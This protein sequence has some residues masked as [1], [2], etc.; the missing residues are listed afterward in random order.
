MKIN[1]LM[2]GFVQQDNVDHRNVV[3]LKSTVYQAMQHKLTFYMKVL[4]S[5]NRVFNVEISF[6]NVKEIKGISNREEAEEYLNDGRHALVKDGGGSNHIVEKPLAR[7]NPVEVRCDCES[8]RFTYAYANRRHNALFPPDFPPYKRKTP[9]RGGRPRRN[10]I[11]LPGRCKHLVVASEF[12]I[13][14]EHIVD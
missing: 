4:G 9:V 3:V 6:D 13:E 2:Y 8:F 1:K 5:H 10:P 12:L 11:K 7:R 14:N